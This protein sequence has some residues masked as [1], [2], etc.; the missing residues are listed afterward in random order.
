MKQFCA[1][2]AKQTKKKLVPQVSALQRNQLLTFSILLSALDDMHLFLFS[3]PEDTSMKSWKINNNNK[4]K[5][6]YCTVNWKCQ[7]CFPFI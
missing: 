2:S 3:L 1:T 6:D 7:D 5:K 4:G